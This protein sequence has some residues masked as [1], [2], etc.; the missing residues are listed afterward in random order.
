MDVKTAAK[1]KVNARLLPA[2]E[3]QLAFSEL[4]NNKDPE[5]FEELKNNLLLKIDSA[6]AEYN[7]LN[8][9][10][11][12]MNEMIP[13][14]KEELDTASQQCEKFQE[15]LNVLTREKEQLENEK[16]EA[17]AVQKLKLEVMKNNPSK[18]LQDLVEIEK[19]N[20][21]DEMAIEETEKGNE[22]RNSGVKEI[23]HGLDLF[24]RREE[25][26]QED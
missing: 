21:E 9:E 2:K 17:E 18:M 5:K 13:K 22:I 11:Q 15:E 7:I 10:T 12:I 4:L 1:I 14:W 6:E 26:K 20:K 8:Q 24:F 3:I 25:P 16:E 23:K 19:R